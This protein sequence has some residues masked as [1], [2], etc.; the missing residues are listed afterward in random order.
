VLA[1]NFSGLI[2]TDT[3]A[4]L[5]FVALRLA[6]AALIAAA[7]IGA[8]LLWWRAAEIAERAGSNRGWWKVLVVTGAVAVAVV[9]L[10]TLGNLPFAYRLQVAR[11]RYRDFTLETDVDSGTIRMNGD[12]GPGFARRLGAALKTPGIKTIEIDS[13]GGLVDEALSAAHAIQAHGGLTLSASGTCNSACLLV[14]MSGDKRIAPLQLNFGFHA[15]APITTI[16]GAYRLEDVQQLGEDAD[17]YLISRGVPSTFAKGARSLGP[18]KVYWVSAI[19]M[20]EAGAVTELTDDGEPVSLAEGKWRTVMRV[21][22]HAGVSR[23]ETDFF[24]LAD[25]IAPAA[26]QAFAGRMLDRAEQ[27]DINGVAAVLREMVAAMTVKAIPAASDAAMAESVGVMSA[28]FQ[29]LQ[30]RERWDICTG[31][32]AGKG[33][34]NLKMPPELI[35]QDFKASSDLVSSAVQ[36][37][38]AKQDVP[39]QASVEG[40][41]L[42]KNTAADMAGKGEDVRQ[43]GKDPKISCLWSANL[44]SSIAAKPAPE[45]ARLYRWLLIRK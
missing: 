36:R 13:I 38:W 28:E 7:G 12:I 2:D 44:M 27:N 16:K 24:L 5:T 11:A 4:P 35:A 8:A 21:I 32:L 39:S 30:S 1:V 40:N 14:F 26:T 25:H 15:T 37:G 18:S 45:A 41:A 9:L 10:V 31:L 43:F 17:R 19:R 23:E 34:G 42:I 29:Y 20:A 33:F 3:I 22:K 6:T